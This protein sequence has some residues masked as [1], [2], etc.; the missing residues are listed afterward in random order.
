MSWAKVETVLSF[1]AIAMIT[2]Y[3]S[4]LGSAWSIKQDNSYY[5]AYPTQ[6]SGSR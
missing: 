6:A 4:R 2:L 5:G 3:A 1:V